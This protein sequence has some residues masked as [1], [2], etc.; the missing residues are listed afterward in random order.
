[1]I[2]KRKLYDKL[3]E[4]KN[5]PIKDSALLIEGARRVGKTTLVLEF[6]KANYKDNYIYIDFKLA[7][8][9]MKDIFNDF[10]D[11]DSFFE[12]LFLLCGKAIKRGGLVIFDEIQYCNKA[13]ETIKYLVLDGRFEYIETGFLISI[14]ENTENIQIPSEEKKLEMYPLDFE[15]F[16]W[17]IGDTYTPTFLRNC[18]NNKKQID[19]KLHNELMQKFRKYLAIG[20]MPKVLDVFLSTNSYYEADN[21]KKD[22]LSLYKDDLRKHDNKYRTYCEVIF[23]AIPYQLSKENSRFF[24]SSST[25]GKRASQFYKSLF[26]LSDYKLVNIVY[27]FDDVSSFFEL[28]KNANQFIIYSVDTGLLVTSL[29]REGG[30]NISD[31]YQ[32]IIFDNIN[33]NFG[34]IFESI[35][36]QMLYAKGIKP[37]F[38][39]FVLNKNDSNK[40]YEIDFMYQRNFKT[41]AL[42]VKSTKRFTT[43]SLDSLS[44]KYQNE[45]FNKIVI[46]QKTFNISDSSLNIPIYML[47]FID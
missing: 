27:N 34:A 44:E 39:T 2:F 17:A 19:N 46:S 7:S 16:L 42:E 26:D 12:K 1:M 9:N 11:I 13:R 35:C 28:S 22:I 10:S 41:Y 32:K 5:S 8:K 40:K 20:G 3:L 37:Y 18:F 21:I 14:K 33:Y 36:C 24:V 45:K 47:P 6:A 23:D 15:E 38:H 29:L 31:A 43:I 30:E 25:S 4:W